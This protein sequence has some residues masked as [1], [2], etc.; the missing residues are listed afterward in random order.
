LALPFY[1]TSPCIACSFTALCFGFQGE[2]TQVIGVTKIGST[3]FIVEKETPYDEALESKSRCAFNRNFDNLF[4]G[5]NHE[6]D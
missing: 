5:V 6:Y 2:R 1:S 4:W 3:G